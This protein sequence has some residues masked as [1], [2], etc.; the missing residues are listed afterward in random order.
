[1]KTD[2]SD[3][4]FL[5]LIR[6][7]S[8]QRLENIIVVT[9]QICH[10][11]NTNILVLEAADHNNG[12]LKALLNKKI[13]Y[14]FL[15]D[16]DPVLYKTYYLNIMALDVNT[17]FLAIWDTDIVIDRIAIMDAIDHL[18]N[19]N[20][21]VSYPYNGKCFEISE[22]LR[23]YYLKKKNSRLLY[24]HKNKLDLLYPH[25]LTGGAV[26]VNTQKYYAAGMEN[27]IH[28]GWGNDDFDRY[29]RFIGLG[30]KIYRVDTCLFHL[31]H[32]RGENSKFR[33]TT[34][35]KISGNERFRIESSSKDEIVTSLK[36]L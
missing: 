7:D 26:F 18:R 6:L 23:N 29:F 9:N 33:S 16:K 17:P 32:P 30:Y 5:I 1:M 15:E 27:E 14:M 36:G 19:G 35:K 8:I 28:Y 34:A 2:L 24:R 4:T 3:I 25:L 10:Y 31:W 12:V 22:L 20:T 11:F 21:D 13:K